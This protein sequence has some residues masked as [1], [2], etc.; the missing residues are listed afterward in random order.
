MYCIPKSTFYDHKTG[1]VS[2][3]KRGPSTVLSSSEE[4]SLVQ[5]ILLM[6]DIGYGCAREQVCLIVKK[7]LDK[8]GRANPFT[9]DY[10][11]KDWWYAFFVG[12]HNYLYAYQNLYN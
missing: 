7:M 11:G 5:R 3:S 12:T 2:T 1:K 4:D 9:D 6:A 10:P 8:D